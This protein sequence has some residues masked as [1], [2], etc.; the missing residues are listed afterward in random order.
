VCASRPPCS[1]RLLGLSARL[2]L[3]LSLSL[4]HHSSHHQVDD[5]LIGGG[6]GGRTS[7]S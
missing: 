4:A 2:S 3:P 7:K 1:H 6:G 5:K